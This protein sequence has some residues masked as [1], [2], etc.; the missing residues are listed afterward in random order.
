MNKFVAWP[1]CITISKA[2]ARSAIGIDP[3]KPLIVSHSKARTRKGVNAAIGKTWF[4]SENEITDAY[5][6]GFIDFYIDGF[7]IW[8]D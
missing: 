3:Y 5:N 1:R 6:A 4:K 2:L 7:I 8:Q